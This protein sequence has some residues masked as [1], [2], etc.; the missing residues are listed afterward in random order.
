MIVDD[1]ALTLQPRVG[2]KTAAHLLSCFGTAEKVFDATQQSLINEAQINPNLAKEIVTKR[3]HKQAEFEIEFCRNNDI[4]P[5]SSTSNLYPPLLKE[6]NDYPH[7]VYY[8]GDVDALQQRMIS[9]VGT[10]K[11]TTY[12]HKVCDNLVSELSQLFPDLVIVS[13]LAYGVDSACHRAALSNNIKTIGIIAS[14]FPNIT[15]SR[16][17]LLATQMIKEGGGILTEYHS[18]NK[19]KGV[20]YTARNRLIAGISN[21]TIIVESDL[22]GGSMI[23]ATMADGYHRVVMAI[24]GRVGESASQGPNNLIRT[25]RARLVTSA[26]DVANELGWDDYEKPKKRNYTASTLSNEAKVILNYIEEGD[27]LSIDLLAE[28]SNL[29]IAELVPLLFELEMDGA[30][31][32]LPGKRY[33]KA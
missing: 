19:D 16:H 32:M 8:K 28:K 17:T 10:R 30:V 33:E 13:G 9:M 25:N 20:T 5:I 14:K 23:T 15:P 2:V 29:S 24:P 21:G 27:T 1:I 7:V 22:F 18:Q 26:R 3:Y 4:I 6:C 11:M 12:G 31:R